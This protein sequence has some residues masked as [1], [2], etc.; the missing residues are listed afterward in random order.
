MK[1]YIVIDG[2]TTNTRICVVSGGELLSSLKLSIG[3]RAALDNNALLVSEIKNGICEAL[4]KAELS[5]N[6][7]E[8]IIASGMITSASGL[9]ELDHIEL[10]A[11]ADIL[12]NNVARVSL[13]GVSNIPFVFIRGVKS[14]SENLR[15]C[16]MMRGEETE[17]MG[18][19]SDKYSDAIYVLPGSH[20][21]V[22][23]V[24]RGGT[25]TDFCTLLTGEMIAALA[26]NTILKDAV[27]LSLSEIEDD[28]LIEGYNYAKSEGLNNALFK[29]RIL[30][31]LFG[32]SKVKCY[33]FFM[34]AV[35]SGEIDAIMKYNE[36]TVVIGGKAQLKH[37][38][39][40]IL[41]AVTDKTVIELTNEEVEDSVV[42][43]A[44]KIYEK[45]Q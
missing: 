26:A 37:A 27:D 4:K 34:G 44:L 33:S 24:T 10:P 13:P 1:N 35:L 39:A 8:C 6:E 16:D 20:S 32:A 11:N 43:G 12:A 38:L 23:K 41:R 18:I 21:K 3:A 7:I 40:T 22:I 30:K 19:M 42:N 9:Y 5:E 31:N 17:L 15:E 36:S 25:I 29:V 2:G 14:Q 28:A 45:T